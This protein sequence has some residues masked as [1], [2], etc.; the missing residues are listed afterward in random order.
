MK[1]RVVFEVTQQSP[2]YQQSIALRYQV[3]RE[4]LGLHFTSEELEQEKDQFHFVCYE[5]GDL[6]GC[7]VL[8]PQP[9]QVIKMRQVA[10]DPA[11]QGLGLGRSLVKF[12][13]EFAKRR[14]FDQMVLNARETAV[15]F[16]ERLGYETVGERFEEVTLPHFKMQKQLR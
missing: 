3:L 2:A 8:V 7:L 13:E 6:A 9:N 15:P 5:N 16:Y 10:V 4:P 1:R 11:F 14:S 12:A